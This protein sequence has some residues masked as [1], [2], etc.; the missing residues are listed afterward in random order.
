MNSVIRD[1]L[2]GQDFAIVIGIDR[3]D[4]P[5]L[6]RLPGAPKDAKSFILWLKRD[7]SMG[8]MRQGRIIT[9]L[10]EARYSHITSAFNKLLDRVKPDRGGRLY[11]FISGHGYADSLKESVVYTTDTSRHTEACFDLVRT[12]DALRYSGLFKEIVVFADCCR[13]IRRFSAT[14]L[15]LKLSQV[16]SAAT[17]FYCFACVFGKGTTENTYGGEERGDF[18]LHLLRALNGDVT[19]ALDHEGRVTAHTLVRHLSRKLVADFDPRDPRVLRDLVLASGFPRP[20]R[21]LDIRLSNGWRDF[22]LFSGTDFS[23]LDWKRKPLEASGT[24]RIEREDD[25]IIVVAVP[26]VSDPKRAEKHRAVGPDER[27]ID[28]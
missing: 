14:G 12:A 11:L 26:A 1:Q 28:M 9:Q 8:N 19:N 20:D 5:A 16:D 18:S 15:P 17:H 10:K 24:F 22:S 6:S 23:P 13:G 2:E 25:S 27:Q 7:H 21:S 4:D 3:Y